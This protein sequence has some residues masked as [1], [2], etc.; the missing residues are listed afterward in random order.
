MADDGQ[1]RRD[2]IELHRLRP[3]CQRCDVHRR[4]RRQRSGRWAAAGRRSRAARCDPAQSTRSMAAVADAARAGRATASGES[5][6]AGISARRRARRR[7]CDSQRADDAVSHLEL[8]ADTPA[9]EPTEAVGATAVRATAASC[10]LMPRSILTQPGVFS[11]K[12]R[13]DVGPSEEAVV[14]A[15]YDEAGM[16]RQ[17][18]RLTLR[19]SMTRATGRSPCRANRQACRRLDDARRRRTGWRASSEPMP[20]GNGERCR[21]AADG[22]RLNRPR[23]EVQAATAGAK[24]RDRCARGSP[25]REAA[26]AGRR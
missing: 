13:Q 4:S 2:R 12:A 17:C 25:D 8:P 23:D 1:L 16:R 7:R 19:Q 24:H 20:A 18:H 5:C 9:T 3:I 21:A 10:W 22:G 11:S 15:S 14:A 6:A 26:A